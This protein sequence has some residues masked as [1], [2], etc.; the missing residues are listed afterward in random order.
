MVLGP[1]AAREVQIVDYR[2]TPQGLMY[3]LHDEDPGVRRM[4]SASSVVPIN[5]M[6]KMLRV[7]FFTGD[8]APVT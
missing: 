2:Y 1:A 3:Q 7:D 5:G 6:T 4:V 8:V